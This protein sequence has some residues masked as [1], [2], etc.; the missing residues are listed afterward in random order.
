[1]GAARVVGGGL[2]ITSALSYAALEL[3]N[4]RG[5][6]T[7]PRT[8]DANALTH[9]PPSWWPKTLARRL[10]RYL[11]TPASSDNK[12]HA[13]RH[14]LAGKRR[15]ASK[16]RDVATRRDGAKRHHANG[17]PRRHANTSHVHVCFVAMGGSSRLDP[18]TAII[19]NI[20]A[21]SAEPE[22]MR[23]HL[24]VTERIADDLVRTRPAWRG[25]PLERTHQHPLSRI[26]GEARKLHARISA[27]ATGPGPIYLWKPLLYLILHSV[28][29]VI[30]LD[31]D[32]FIV[33]DIRRLWDVFDSFGSN[34]LI[35]LVEEQ[36]PTYM[37]A[38]ALGGVGFN[39]G[40]QLLKLRKMRK[41]KEYSGIVERYADRKWVAMKEGG[42]GW[43]GDQTLYSWMSVNAS[44]AAHIFFR[45]PCGW[46]RQTG[47]HAAGWKG[48][49][50]MHACDSP[51]K[52][53]HANGPPGHK[54]FIEALKRD[55]QG[56]SCASTVQSF[57]QKPEFRE[58]TADRRVLDMIGKQCCR[59]DKQ[60][61]S[62]A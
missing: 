8:Y 26:S 56:R 60:L 25:V 24:I 47:T 37:E 39:G 33:E 12:R 53:I 16:R 10:E 23:Y 42:I 59:S 6:A 52:L 36:A 13:H 55:P 17:E 46:N 2:A 50:R 14:K 35:G 62:R 27:T 43:L 5:A 49:W 58:G 51:C 38:R 21:M 61:A 40:V 1:M 48:F 3:A 22:L 4:A 34:Q 45:L 31:T 28:P 9:G 44:E 11:A 15:D 7:Q 18:A 29:R 30:V 20:E 19:R 41:S 57:R 32:V 54:A